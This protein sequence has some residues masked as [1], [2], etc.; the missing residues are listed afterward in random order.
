MQQEI[1]VVKGVFAGIFKEMGDIY[2]EGL[3]GV[4]FEYMTDRDREFLSTHRPG[5]EHL[6][7]LYSLYSAVEK[8]PGKIELEMLVSVEKNSASKTVIFFVNPLFDR[9]E[10]IKELLAE[11]KEKVDKYL[12]NKVVFGRLEH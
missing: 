9:D 7:P 3:A 8:F 12:P 5:M 10:R 11:A 6:F 4:L 2:E 1:Q